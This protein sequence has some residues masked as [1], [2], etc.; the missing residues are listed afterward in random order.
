MTIS[1]VIPN[2]NDVRIRRAVASVQTQS[3]QNFELIIIDG[4]SSIEEILRYY[5]ECGADDVVVEP[6]EGIFDALNKGVARATGDV[7]F[8]LGS[9]DELSDGDVFQS[10]ANAFERQRDLDGVCIGCEFIT[11]EGRVIRSWY[12]HAVTAGRMKRGLLPPHFSLFLK[13]RLYEEVGEFRFREGGQIACDTRWLMDL[14]VLRP[15]LRVRVLGEHHLRMEY[16]GASTGSVGAVAKQYVA[17]HRYARRLSGHLP[18]WFLYSPVRTLSK[19]LQV[20]LF[21]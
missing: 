1:V 7:V 6:D 9:D 3:Y 15:D 10:V 13:R 17:V 19:L 5:P 4:G 14:A 12:P 21:R 8:L 11:A 16:G 18:F 2:F 20:R